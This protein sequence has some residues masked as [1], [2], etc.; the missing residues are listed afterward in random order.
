MEIYN[1]YFIWQHVA[2]VVYIEVYILYKIQKYM[3]ISC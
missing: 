2:L 1:I 3:N